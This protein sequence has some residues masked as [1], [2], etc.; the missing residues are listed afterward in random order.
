MDI[1]VS[2][3]TYNSA[4]TI[5]GCLDSILGQKGVDAEIIVA[6]NHSTD[7]T[8]DL[9]RAFGD[10]V[11]A[12]ANAENIGFGA[13]HNLA[14]RHAGPS[15][16]QLVLNPDAKIMESDGL[17]HLVEWMDAHPKCGLAGMAVVKDGRRIPPKMDYPGAKGAPVDFS[18]LPGN[19]A[20]VVGASMMIRRAAFEQVGGFDEEFFLYGEET[21]LCLRL[22]KAGHEIGFV[23]GVT[24]EHIGGVSEGRTPAYDLQMQRQKRLHRLYRK[25]YP[26]E[27]ALFIIRR[28][29]RRSRRRLA[30]HALK[31][32]LFGMSEAT[33]EN[34]G[35]YRAICESCRRFLDETAA[36]EM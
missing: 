14:A 26:P 34:C 7:T 22:R 6:D 18:G 17:K 2:I 4:A 10:Q 20:W 12:I 29:L 5:R 36:G 32:R 11:R 3:V 30:L 23:E 8:L 27:A 31:G 19:I 13:G 9:L 35:R 15:R 33:R 21:D 24:V 16:Y 28:D 25:H 1:T